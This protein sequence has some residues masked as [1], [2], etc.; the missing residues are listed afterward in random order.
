M[1]ELAL[2]RYLIDLV[3]DS[4][5]EVKANKVK[6]INLRLGQASAMARALHFCFGSASRGTCCEG[7]I[8][9]I[10]EIPLTVHCRHCDDVKTPLGRYSFRCPD[11]GFPSAKIVTGREM[12]LISVEVAVPEPMPQL[13]LQLVNQPMNVLGGHYA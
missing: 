13:Q 12:E 7:A 3:T 9:H 11:C 8:L 4:V 6:Q 2:A 1:H 5:S 10:D